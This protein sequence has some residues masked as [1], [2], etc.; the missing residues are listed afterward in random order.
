MVTVTGRTGAGSCVTR[1]LEDGAPPVATAGDTA[2]C[3]VRKS[4]RIAPRAPLATGTSDPSPAVKI[5]G[6]AAP[7]VKLNTPICPRLVTSRVAGPGGISYGIWISNCP[8][9]T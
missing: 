8:G 9:D 1:V 3:P 2:P 7:T 6:A 5:P 4:E